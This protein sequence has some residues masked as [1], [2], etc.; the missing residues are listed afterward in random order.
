MGV[1]EVVAPRRAV[2]DPLPD[3]VLA[4]LVERFLG[5]HF[6]RLDALPQQ[7]FTRVAGDDCWATVA[8]TKGAAALGQVKPGLAFGTTVAGQAVSGQDGGDHLVKEILR[9]RHRTLADCCR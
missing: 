7:A 8:T 6:I 9:E 5:R 3:D 4:C 1:G 2:L